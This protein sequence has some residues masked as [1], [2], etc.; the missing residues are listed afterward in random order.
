[1]QWAETKWNMVLDP[2]GVVYP[3]QLTPGGWCQTW[4]WFELECNIMGCA[5]LHTQLCK[6]FCEAQVDDAI[7]GSDDRPEVVS[8]LIAAMA[9]PSKM[10]PG[11]LL[12]GKRITKVTSGGVEWTKK[13]GSASVNGFGLTLAE[14]VHRLAKRYLDLVQTRYTRNFK[15]AATRTSRQIPSDGAFG[16]LD[17]SAGLIKNIFEFRKHNKPDVVDSTNLADACV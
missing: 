1:M 15:P 13:T 17:E 7:F 5:G 11:A 10:L 8:E 3:R 14:F 2:D 4:S 16:P 9:T 12:D 6:Y